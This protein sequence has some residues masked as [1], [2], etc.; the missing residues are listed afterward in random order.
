M[1]EVSYLIMVTGES[2]LVVE[3]LCKDREHLASFIKDKLLQV[4][5]VL[6]AQ[7][8]LILHTYKMAHGAKTVLAHGVSTENP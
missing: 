6:R 7:T 2:D 3:V 8:S 5:G 4:P 1:P